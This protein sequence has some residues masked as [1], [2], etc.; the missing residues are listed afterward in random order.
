L[1]KKKKEFV[2]ITDEE[3]QERIQCAGDAVE[4]IEVYTDLSG[5]YPDDVGKDLNLVI[6]DTPGTDSARGNDTKKTVEESKRLSVKSHIEITKDVLKSKQK[7]MVILVSDDK[8]EDD[9]IVDLLNIIEESAESDDGAFNDRFLFVMNMCDSLTYSNKG[10]TLDNY[11]R[12]F[13]ANIQKVP[14]SP[15]MRN[16]VNPRVFPISSGVALAVANGY[17]QKPDIT[18][19]MTKKE[20]LYGYYEGFCK[21]VY[22]Y[23]PQELEGNFNQYKEQIMTGHKSYKNYCLEHK[24]SISEA[25]KREYSR[26]L[27]GELSIPERIFIHSGVPALKCAIQ[28]YIRSY[29]Y[30]IKVRQLLNCFKDILEELCKL[31]AVELEVLNAAKKDYSSAV[32]SRERAKRVRQEEEKRKILLQDVSV[33]MNRVNKKIEGINETITEINGI[34]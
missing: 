30:P 29:A 7:E 2:C 17:T 26:K 11:I 15:R 19:S 4:T 34:V 25:V 21:K 32:T 28:D 13:V 6:I 10:E 23:S 9:N 3:V 16:I 18:E 20:E 1:N 22:Y 27:A 24:S 14:N 31:N 8:L 33:R 12:N 5:L